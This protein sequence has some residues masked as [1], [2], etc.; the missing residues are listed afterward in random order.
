MPVLKNHLE[1]FYGSNGTPRTGRDS[2]EPHRLLKKAVRETKHIDE[3]LHDARAGAVVLGNDGENPVGRDDLVL[4]SGERLRFLTIARTI[5]D[6]EWQSGEIEKL[7]LLADSSK[8]VDRVPGD[9]D[10]VAVGPIRTG[11]D[12]DHE[13]L[14]GGPLCHRHMKRPK[15]RLAF[16][17]HRSVNTVTHG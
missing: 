11:Y 14:P 2:D 13:F 9:L 3:V 15:H 4:K 5:K 12:G 17:Q 10:G 1:L 7:D 16:Q 8:A 6:L